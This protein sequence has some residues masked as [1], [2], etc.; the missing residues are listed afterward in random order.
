MESI[1]TAEVMIKGKVTG[2][3]IAM[4]AKGELYTTVS[5]KYLF[6]WI[7]R[8]WTQEGRG[9]TLNSDSMYVYSD[10]SGLRF[11]VHCHK[12]G[13]LEAY[14]EKIAHQFNFCLVEKFINSLL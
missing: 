7:E 6:N 3:Y 1:E 10:Q 4:S 9:E 2:K 11:R 12:Q 5:N 13:Y 8:W 14:M